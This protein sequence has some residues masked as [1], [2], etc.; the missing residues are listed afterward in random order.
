MAVTSRKISPGAKP[1]ASRA[2][3]VVAAPTVV[4]YVSPF[5]VGNRVTHSSFGDG[6]VAEVSK[7]QLAIS[8]DKV[9]SK[10]ILDSFVT[11]QKS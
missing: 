5:A 10:V 8:F 11:R 1:K 7:N 9:G 4:E 2:K 3:K 6:E